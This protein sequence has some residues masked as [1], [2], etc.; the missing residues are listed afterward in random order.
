MHSKERL[1]VELRLAVSPAQC[2]VYSRHTPRIFSIKS[3]W[4]EPSRARWPPE[5]ER[6]EQAGDVAGWSTRAVCPSDKDLWSQRG[7]REVLAEGEE[8]KADQLCLLQLQVPD[9]RE[10][11]T[12]LAWRENN[13]SQSTGLGTFYRST[14]QGNSEGLMFPEL[15]CP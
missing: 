8:G 7:G 5:K 2:L 1:R 15:L 13:L 14:G 3:A 12:S 10:R 4:R 6:A 11:Q 9:S